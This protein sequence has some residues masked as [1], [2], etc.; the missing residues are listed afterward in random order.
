MS[1]HKTF[2]EF[3]SVA[4]P[5]IIS[6]L[7]FQAGIFSVAVVSKFQNKAQ[8]AGV[9]LAFAMMNICSIYFMTGFLV[10]IDTLS[11]QAYGAGDMK[12]CGVLL[13]RAMLLTHIA[14]IPVLILL[15]NQRS[16]LTFL[17]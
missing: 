3:L 10:P 13:N 6:R 4:V 17:N 5:A 15:L 8:I 7:S 9:G 14:M 12:K 16:I 1:I 11:S 2:K